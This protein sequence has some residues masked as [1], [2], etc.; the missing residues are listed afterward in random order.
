MPPVAWYEGPDFAESVSSADEVR[1][2]EAWLACD[3]CVRLVSEG[4]REALVLRSAQDTL[5]SIR[6]NFDHLFW[7]PRDR[8]L[9]GTE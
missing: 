9:G 6:D 3:T 2:E 8:A 5:T 1:S 4:D 7:T